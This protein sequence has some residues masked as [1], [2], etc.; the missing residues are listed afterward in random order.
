MKASTLNNRIA[1][2]NNKDGSQPQNRAYKAAMQV[3]MSGKARVGYYTG[4]GRFTKASRSNPEIYLDSWKIDYKT[5]NDAPKGGVTGEVVEL[6]D[7]GKKQVQAYVSLMLRIKADE[8]RKRKEL[9]EAGKQA[10]K[11]EMLAKY[12]SVKNIPFFEKWNSQILKDESGLSWNAYRN[13]LKLADPEG[14][15]ELKAQFKANQK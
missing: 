15:A 5:Y 13:E 11:E 8:E 2:S 4:S 3:I 7:K 6:T 10:Y 14:W 12:E 9:I 1:K